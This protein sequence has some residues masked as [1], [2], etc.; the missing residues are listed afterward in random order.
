MLDLIACWHG[1]VLAFVRLLAHCLMS[2]RL[3]DACW[4]HNTAALAVPAGPGVCTG[5][6]CAWPV[7]QAT[8]T[9]AQHHTAALELRRLTS[10]LRA[11]LLGSS[12]MAGVKDAGMGQNHGVN[13]EDAQG[14]DEDTSGRGGEGRGGESLGSGGTQELLD[15]LAAELAQVGLCDWSVTGGDW[16]VVWRGWCGWAYLL[17]R[18]VFMWGL[19]AGLTSTKQLRQEVQCSHLPHVF[20]FPVSKS[21]FSLLEYTTRLAG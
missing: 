12:P 4:W 10:A 8:S 3:L 13:G 21:L 6:L 15:Q 20:H 5:K 16:S 1:F 17:M 14:A 19:G 9:R 18:G 2:A 11:L 7:P